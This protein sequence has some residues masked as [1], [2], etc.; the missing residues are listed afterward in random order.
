MI[1]I[2]YD[3]RHG[4]LLHSS[5]SVK[6]GHL[7]SSPI[8]GVV[9]CLLRDF[10]PK[11]PHISEHCDHSDQSLTEHG[12]SQDPLRQGLSSSRGPQGLPD[13]LGCT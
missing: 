8:G 7:L 6:S 4:F 9:T 11:S 3:S 12:R 5:H 2:E 1:I 13:E 10:T